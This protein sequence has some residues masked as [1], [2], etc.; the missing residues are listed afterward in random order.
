MFRFCPSLATVEAFGAVEGA[1]DLSYSIMDGAAG[2]VFLTNLGI[3]SGTNPTVNL[4]TTATGDLA[5]DTS[6]GTAK[7][8]TVI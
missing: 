7:G 5:L 6:I 1:H 3:F 8:W 4:P 2:N